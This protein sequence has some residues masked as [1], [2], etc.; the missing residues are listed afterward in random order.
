MRPSLTILGFLFFYLTRPAAADNNVI[1]YGAD[2][3]FRPYEWFS[4]D[5]KL[6]GF[7]IELMRAIAEKSGR[8]VNFVTGAWNSI[9]SDFIDGKVQVVS[10]F[11][12]PVRHE[13]ADFS[14]PHSVLASEIFIRRGSKPIVSL[15][16]ST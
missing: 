4:D 16:R 12:Q 10:M 11:D 7:Q 14:K 2:E 3:A 13:Y 5:G 8:R 1:V 15:V 6:E 9:R